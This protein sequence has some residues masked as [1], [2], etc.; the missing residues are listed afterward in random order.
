LIEQ[1]INSLK[2][3]PNLKIGVIAST[4]SYY[5]LPNQKEEFDKHFMDMTDIDNPKVKNLDLFQRRI[6]GTLSYYRTTGTEYFPTVLPNNIQFLP[7][8]DHQFSIYT[9]IRKKERDMDTAQKRHNND[10]MSEKSSVYRAFSRLVCNFVF[11]E[12]IK[13]LFPQ[14]V[15]KLMKK[16]LGIDDDDDEDDDT[17]KDAKSNQKK[18]K[19]EYDKKFAKYV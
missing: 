15:K 14:D 9:D 13:R 18:V 8:T 10:V 19:E 4:S 16:E 1:I 12:N 5:A 6:L 7:M 2:T 17:D 3:V 11:P